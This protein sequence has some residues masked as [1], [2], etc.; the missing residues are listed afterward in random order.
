MAAKFLLMYI[1]EGLVLRRTTSTAALAV[2]TAALA[3]A[4]VA[5]ATARAC[6]LW[7]WWW[8]SEEDASRETWLVGMVT[9]ILVAVTLAVVVMVLASQCCITLSCWFSGFLKIH[10]RFP[11]FCKI[12]K[13][14]QEKKYTTLNTN[15]R[16][17]KCPFS[18]KDEAPKEGYLFLF[19]CFMFFSSSTA[20]FL[21]SLLSWRPES[22]FDH[23]QPRAWS[24][25]LPHENV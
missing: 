15:K 21:I 10:L 5:M 4:V 16:K 3:A 20:S 18:D 23:C 7:L 25:N 12:P 22:P 6:D 8:T 24:T 17:K 9:E 13:R 1:E 11:L 14:N 2:T 19:V